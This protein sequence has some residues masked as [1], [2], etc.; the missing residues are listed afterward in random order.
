MNNNIANAE[1]EHKG[2]APM[3]KIKQTPLTEG[4]KEC[5]RLV[6]RLLTSKEIARELRISPFTVDQR[7]DAARRKLGAETR[8]EA[9]RIFALQEDEYISQRFV[10]ETPQL[11]ISGNPPILNPSNINKGDFAGRSVEPEGHWVLFKGL[12]NRGDVFRLT[13]PTIGGEG[14]S[15]SKMGVFRAI[16]KTALFSIVS[17]TA[18]V[19][20][21]SGLMRLL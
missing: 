6:D 14:H 1:Q 16:V 11:A 17:V 7:L 13:M 21:I 5:L 15:L 12:G 10:Y 20:V 8:K 19:A 9:A 18:L 2:V 4:Q 3:V